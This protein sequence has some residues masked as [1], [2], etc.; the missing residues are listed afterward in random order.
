MLDEVLLGEAGLRDDGADAPPKRLAA[1]GQRLGP[2]HLGQVHVDERQVPTR[3]GVA[4]RERH[5]VLRRRRARDVNVVDLLYLHCCR[6]SLGGARFPTCKFRDTG[7]MYA[8]HHHSCE[9]ENRQ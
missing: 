5:R 9:N 8:A 3:L 1:V 7:Y 2:V 6:C 4:A